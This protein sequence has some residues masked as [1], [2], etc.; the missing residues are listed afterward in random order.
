MHISYTIKHAVYTGGLDKKAMATLNQI[1]HFV[2]LM[3]E[4]RSFDN[5]LGKLYPA[6]NNFAGITGNE[7]NPGISTS[8]KVW[9]DIQ[10][11]GVMALPTPDPG[12]LFDDINHQL[13][14][15]QPPLEKPSM[16]GF[17][18]NYAKNGGN[19]LDIMHCFEPSQVPALSALARS[20]A[21]CDYWYASA[22]CQTWPNRFFLHAAT[23][24]GYQNNSPPHFPYMMSTIFNELENINCDWKIY[25]HDFPQALTLT[26]LWGYL[27]HFHLFADFL[28]DAK[29]G[30][31]PS[32][33]FIEPRYF[34]D[35]NWPN[36]MHPPHNITYGDQLI[37]EVYNA[38]YSSPNWPSTMLIVLF[39]EHGGCFDHIS[40]PS[41]IPPYQ[42]CAGQIFAFDRYGVRVPAI[43]ASPL[44]APQTVFRSNQQWP[45]DH[46]SIIKTL[47]KRFGIE[48]PMTARD[49]CA[50]DLEQALNLDTP[51]NHGRED[52]IAQ[53]ML[54]DPVGLKNAQ[55]APLN[56]FQHSLYEAVA[57]LK[58]LVAGISLN[59]H[60]QNLANNQIPEI[61]PAKNV[62]EVVS[63]TKDV[64]SKLLQI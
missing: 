36:D 58:P 6:S 2:V 8:I 30:E 29:N 21:V 20:Y 41:A 4:N 55:L 32:Y 63:L 45:F 40:P 7:S 13:F 16:Q 35:N 27:K 52:V 51:T 31:L 18:L 10:N 44:I 19:P 42:P 62:S 37:A 59:D 22:P 17:T 53:S 61:P 24:G 50:P 11:T 49:A 28:E 60:I 5:L 64:M 56:E 23:A 54:P 47:R 46:T 34:A 15:A 26:K 57:L 3:L 12:E 48:M 33:T 38:L 14:G 9:S 25:F 1:K 39:D 43:V